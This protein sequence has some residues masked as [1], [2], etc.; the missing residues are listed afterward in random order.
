MNVKNPIRLLAAT[1]ITLFLF[2]CAQEPGPFVR[3]NPLDAHGTNWNDIAALQLSIPTSGSYLNFNHTS[4][5]GSLRLVFSALDIDGETGPALYSLYIGQDSA[6]IA[7]CYTGGDTTTIIDT[8]HISQTYYWRLSARLSLGDSASATGSFI[9]SPPAPAGMKLIAA[10]TFPMGSTT[11]S[12]EQPVHSVTMSAFWMDSTEVTQADYVALMGVNPS[13]FSGVTRGPVENIT[14]YDAVLYCNKRSKR[15]GKDTVYRYTSISGTA[16]NGCSGLSGLI[17]D[18]SKSGYRL[19][20]DAQREYACRAG[21]T[22]DYYWGSKT[23]DNYAW[24]S[25]NSGNTTHTVATKLPNA[26]GLYD[27]SGN[28]Y[29]WCNDW[30]GTYSSG[31]QTDPQG[32][33]SGSYRVLRGGSWN[34]YTPLLRSA[35]RSGSD[36]DY[37]RNDNGFRAVC[38][39]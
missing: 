8:V 11:K 29:E 39:R 21:T 30:Y 22:T 19:P 6:N 3:N 2:S 38:P 23:I 9:T 37:R 4:Q 14:W 28:V 20:T 35:N 17:I 12:T 32:A 24:Y 18:T 13:N 5:K 27:M 36:P 34:F 7:L 10:G 31:A 25:S 26:W 33:T 15:D 1:A 16:G